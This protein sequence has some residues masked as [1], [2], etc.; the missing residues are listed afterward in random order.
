MQCLLKPDLWP[1]SKSLT[2]FGWVI[3]GVC[4][5]DSYMVQENIFQYIR[6]GKINVQ[7]SWYLYWTD[8][9]KEDRTEPNESKP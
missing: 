3:R 2:A 7:T 5:C 8:C 1:E 4:V 6:R 9:A